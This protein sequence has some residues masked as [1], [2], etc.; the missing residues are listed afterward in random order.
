M[1]IFSIFFIPDNFHTCYLCSC[2]VSS[3]KCA[4][5]NLTSAVN[6]Q[7]DTVGKV[8]QTSVC[9]YNYS[10]LWSLQYQDLC[11]NRLASI[12]TSGLVPHMCYFRFMRV[13]FA[14]ATMFQY[15][16]FSWIQINSE[17][18]ADI[19]WTVNLYSDALDASVGNP[20]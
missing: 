13:Y 5:S 11:F 15:V 7:Y 1:F 12:R 17:P 4:K 6:R 2:L 10:P 3:S 19:A 20:S 16:L 8:K 18:M 9:N 14:L